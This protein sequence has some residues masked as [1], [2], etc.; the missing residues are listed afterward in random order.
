[1]SDSPNILQGQLA[2]LRDQLSAGEPLAAMHTFDRLLAT[3]P[4]PDGAELTDWLV[5]SVGREGL[6]SLALAYATA[7][8][9]N[10]A[11]GRRTCSACNLTGRDQ[12]G[13]ICRSCIG[14]RREGCRICHG[15]GLA[16]YG[17]CPG[18]LRP[19]VLS[20]RLCIAASKATVLVPKK[21]VLLP[22]LTVPA[23]LRRI[24]RLNKL[25]GVLENA[26]VELAGQQAR[27]MISPTRLQRAKHRFSTIHRALEAGIREMLNR[28]AELASM[29]T[30]D[31]DQDVLFYHWLAD[32]Q[33]FT[34]TALQHDFAARLAMQCTS[35]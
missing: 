11:H 12:H 19:L 18:D 5:A 32:S 22:E 25:A 17:K 13:R 21:G 6:C 16:S 23:C 7:P 29:G 28:T 35:D 3:Q 9:P 10:C 14:T 20:Y 24:T 27:G 15:D 30:G 33:K 26:A 2:S 1:M 8:C 31:Q 34:G 4:I